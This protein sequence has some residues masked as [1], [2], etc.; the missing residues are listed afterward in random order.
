MPLHQQSYGIRAHH[1]MTFPSILFF[2]L[3]LDSSVLYVFYMVIHCYQKQ[4][5]TALWS[6]DERNYLAMY[7]TVV[8]SG[9]VDI[10]VSSSWC[11]SQQEWSCISI[12]G[13]I[14]SNHWKTW[15]IKGLEMRDSVGFKC[16]DELRCPLQG[17][18]VCFILIKRTIDISFI[19]FYQHTWLV[20]NDRELWII[21]AVFVALW[22]KEML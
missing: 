20:R 1:K 21:C 8:W 11:W 10:W 12:T 15:A 7:K 2:T 3:I 5:W 19:H 22:R 13:F 4:T 14:P 9:V 17:D 6:V 16:W 18:H